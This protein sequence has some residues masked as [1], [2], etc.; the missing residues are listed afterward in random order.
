MVH[1]VSTTSTATPIDTGKKDCQKNPI[2]KP[3][4]NVEYDHYMGGVDHSDQ[5]VSYTTFDCRTLKWWKRV[6]FHVINLAVLNAYLMYKEKVGAKNA[7]LSRVFRREL[8][9]QII[10]SVDPRELPAW[11]EKKPVGRPSANTNPDTVIRLQG[12]IHGHMP[13]KIKGAP[14]SWNQPQLLKS[15]CC[16]RAC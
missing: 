3:E 2:L 14:G 8:V 15:V 12:K 16:M 1:F 6:I 13:V 11:A 5:M 9:K 7:V 4:V 10:L